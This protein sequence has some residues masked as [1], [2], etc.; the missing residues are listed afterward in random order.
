MCRSASSRDSASDVIVPNGDF[1]SARVIN[2]TFVDLKRRIILPVGSTEQHGAFAP[3]GTDT[4]VAK[5]IAE[6]AGQA[7]G[8][9]VAPLRPPLL[10]AK[11]LTAVEATPGGAVWAVGW[12]QVDG[13]W[14]RRYEK[15]D[16]FVSLAKL[17]D[18]ANAGVTM[19]VKN[20]FGIAP[21]SA[22]T[23]SVSVN[24]AEVSWLPLDF[25]DPIISSEAIQQRE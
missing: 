21:G 25:L 24:F 17:K 18:H 1:T 16:V 13:A 2:W 12:R 4:Y 20:L 5:A 3:L 8:V 22:V 11:T 23:V 19:T 9:L 6:G 10:L 7:T 14:N 15:T